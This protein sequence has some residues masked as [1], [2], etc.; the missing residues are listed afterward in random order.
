MA[1]PFSGGCRCGAVRFE[2]SAEPLLA[3]YCHCRDCQFSAGGAFATVVLVLRDSVSLTGQPR[4]YTVRGDSGGDVTRHFCPT[5]GTPIYSEISANPA[6]LAIKAGTLEDAS[7]VQPTI[8]LWTEMK[9]PW[10]R[11]PEGIASFPRN[12]PQ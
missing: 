5:C 4:G 6:I 1:A 11:I 8:E 9:Q 3:G 2:C 12:P 10:A 7:W